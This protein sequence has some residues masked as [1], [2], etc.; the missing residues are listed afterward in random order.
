[1]K[2][3][4][5]LGIFRPNLLVFQ[6]CQTKIFSY[7]HPQLVCFN[8]LEMLIFTLSSFVYFCL[9]CF[10]EGEGW[11]RGW[12]EGI[13]MLAHLL[14]INFFHRTIWIFKD[15]SFSPPLSP[16]PLPLPLP[17]THTHTPTHTHIRTHTHAH[18][19]LQLRLRPVCSHNLR[20]PLKPRHYKIL[21]SQHRSRYFHLHVHLLVHCWYEVERF[22]ALQT[23]SQLR[24]A[25]RRLEASLHSSLL[26]YH[27][28]NL[29]K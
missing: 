5:G 29:N 13:Y 11:F 7:A 8:F 19:L 27:Y 25:V 26:A 1:M 6:I 15:P 14:C 23:C 12:I 3:K 18:T 21:K 10:F 28:R 4:W 17:A 2:G 24:D 16:H 9:V 20:W 22:W